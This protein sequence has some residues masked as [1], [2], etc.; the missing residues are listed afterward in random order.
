MSAAGL[1]GPNLVIFRIG[2]Y[3]LHLSGLD[4]SCRPAHQPKGTCGIKVIKLAWTS[5]RHTVRRTKL[6][7]F[8]FNPVSCEGKRIKGGER[9]ES[10]PRIGLITVAMRHAITVDI[11]WLVLFGN[12]W[13]EMAIL[14]NKL[15]NVTWVMWQSITKTFLCGLLGKQYPLWWQTGSITL[16][17]RKQSA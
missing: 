5:D 10:F 4:G 16:C 9:D 12:I 13:S 11:I 7:S 8:M 3:L 6:H 17:A 15:G 1:L 14:H 2:L